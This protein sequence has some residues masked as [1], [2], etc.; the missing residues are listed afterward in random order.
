LGASYH[1]VQS[2]AGHVAYVINGTV[3]SWKD[4][5][6]T[7]IPRKNIGVP[8]FTAIHMPAQVKEYIEKY[9][10]PKN[11]VVGGAIFPKH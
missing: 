1:N 4:T 3:W 10:Q 7:T 6:G 5:G 9:L 8:K 2:L 11:F